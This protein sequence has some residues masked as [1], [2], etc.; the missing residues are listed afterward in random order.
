MTRRAT[1]TA[2]RYEWIGEKKRFSCIEWWPISVSHR[3]IFD[4]RVWLWVYK[5][6]ITS[7]F[8]VR[9]LYRIGWHRENKFCHVNLRNFSIAQRGAALD[10]TFACHSQTSTQ[11]LKPCTWSIKWQMATEFSGVPHDLADSHRQMAT[12]TVSAVWQQN[13]QI[14]LAARA[15]RIAVSFDFRAICC[16]IFVDIL[17]FDLSLSPSFS[18]VDVRCGLTDTAHRFQRKRQCCHCQWSAPP[19]IAAAMLLYFYF[20][21]S[22]RNE[23]I[24]CVC[25]TFRFHFY[26][27]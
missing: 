4:W 18:E 17:F 27:F 16:T 6:K 9:R 24:I 5:C 10:Y 13:K 19:Q 20:C 2:A 25:C 1:T 26:T 3:H 7:K 22:V 14:V 8:S 21:F 23:R 11:I 15:Y 12:W